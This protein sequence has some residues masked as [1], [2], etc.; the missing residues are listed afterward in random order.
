[1]VKHLCQNEVPDKEWKMRKAWEAEGPN[2][3]ERKDEI[4]M[5]M[6]H[7]CKNKESNTETKNGGPNQ[8]CRDWVRLKLPKPGNLWS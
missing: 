2:R 1:M 5:V 7:L 3:A 4:M 6:M 8:W